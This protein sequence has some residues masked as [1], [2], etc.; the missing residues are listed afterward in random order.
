M[1]ISKFTQKSQ[2]VVQNCEKIAMDYGHQEIAQ[3][4]LLA[5]MLTVED[6]LIRK[7]IEKMG[8]EPDVFMAQIDGLLTKRPK[9]SG[10]QLHI[11]QYLNQTLIYAEDEAKH[12]GD[13]YVSVEHLFLSLLAHP[14]KDVKALLKQCQ[15]TKERFLQALSKV[16][17]NQRVTSDNPE[18]TYDT[19]EKYGQDLV[20]RAKDGKLDPVIG[21][22]SE[23]R[24]IIRILS[25]KT[26]N[27][28]VLIG[29]PGV[30]KTAAVEGLAQR[31]VR[32][33]VPETLKDKKIFALDMGALIAGAKYRGEFEE[34]LKAVL[35]EVK[36]SDGQII[37][38]VDEL[39]TIVGAGKTDGA[40]DAGNMLKPMLARG[41]LHCIGATTLDEYRMYIEKDAAL[42]RR[43][44]P[45]MVTE[46]TVEDTISILRG[47]KDR[48]EVFH[49]V[50]ITDAAL[51]A[52]ATLSNRYISDRFLPDKAIDLVDEACAMIKTELDSLP[53]ELDAVQRKIMQLE[54]EEA[55]LKKESDNLSKERLENLQKELAELK[56]NFTGQKAKWDQE[57]S[58][59][60]KVNKLKEQINGIQTEMETAK[61]EYNLEKLA[62]LQYGKLPELEKKLQAEED[63]VKNN[64]HTLVQE[65]VTDDEIAKIISKWT[66]IP[67]AKLNEG[68]REKTLHLEDELHK[69][70]IG[71]DEG[72]KLVS[73]AILRSKA[74]IKD[75]SKPIGSFLFL[76][77]TGVGKT[78]LAKTLAASLFDDENN[79][80]RI[81]MSEYME[82]YSVSRLIGAPPGYVGYEEGGQLT[83]AVR[84][85]PYSVVLFDEIE[86]AHPDVFNVLLQVLDDGRI[87][88]SQGRTVDF[89]N[90]ILI[91][92]SN[93][94]AGYLLEGIGED[95]SI[96]SE[97][98]GMVMNELRAHFRP[99]FLN[100]LDE[101]ILFKPLTK[102]DIGGI[103]HLI[104][105]DLN[106][107]LADRE[108]SI[109]ILPAAEKF[110]VEN[111]YDPVYGARPLKRYIQKYVETL[112]A[113]LILSDAVKA[114]DVI[115]ISVQDGKLSAGCRENDKE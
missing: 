22:D 60:D 12:M 99:E 24:N 6:S 18:A 85:K 88:D 34:R 105:D 94:G 114:K 106:R 84:R 72:V 14:D 74:G 83:E 79:M 46:P 59:V 56:D 44:Q 51:V 11:D 89:K 27:N 3:P 78:E 8:I 30:G 108:L 97:A 31:I 86:K 7:L 57:K 68:E 113:K 64:D 81:D 63:K 20:E 25:R 48:Y 41:E 37:L 100:R 110:I 42:E 10:G 67:V 2:E 58:A 49:G 92:T 91:M 13:E 70:V 111:A 47:L 102:E 65:N 95:G 93:I 55:A 52:A 54:I 109:E 17:G 50:K 115:V 23:I 112:S 9:V 15:I 43:F 82:K 77:P 5:S 66:G 40:M 76:G 90:T 53:A 33:D 80:V 98:E 71:Q 87:T 4:H 32:G 101:T 36:K 19:L 96:N 21:R 28:P 39:H 103:I 62:E 75:P 69:R 29:E 61:R 107:R 104:V 1:N 45:V 16:R 38:F 35:E 73:E 26:K